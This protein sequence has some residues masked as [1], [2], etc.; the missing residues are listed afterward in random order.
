[1]LRE[2]QLLPPEFVQHLVRVLPNKFA[3]GSRTADGDHVYSFRDLAYGFSKDALEDRRRRI[4][5][6]VEHQYRTFCQ[7]AEQ[8]TKIPACE[9]SEIRKIFGGEIGQRL[10]RAHR[11][12][13][14]S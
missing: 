5:A 8:L 6:V 3:G 12:D 10:F 1:M 11:F 13:E 2:P 7:A 4:V 14:F 9:T